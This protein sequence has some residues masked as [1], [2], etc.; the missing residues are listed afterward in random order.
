MKEYLELVEGSFTAEHEQRAQE[1]PYVAYS[2]QDDKVMYSSLTGLYQMVDLGAAGIWADRNIGA[3]SPEDAGLYFQWGDSHGYTADQVG[4][5]KVFNFDN[6]FDTTDGGSTYN[7]YNNNGGLTVLE[8]EDD[9][10]T[11]HMGSEWR[12]PTADEFSTLI[13]NTTQV[14]IDVDGNE[15]SQQE[16]Q[17]TVIASGKLKGVKFIAT[18][19]NSIFIPASGIGYSSS[20][21]GI[22]THSRLWSSDLDVSSDGAK[23][24]E[25][26]NTGGVSVIRYGRGYGHT[27]RAIKA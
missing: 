5:D 10:A 2:V 22:N 12:M 7:K 1:W 6:Y 4:V 23:D 26:N 24:L 15:F 25:I 18:N 8:S 14:F 11:V 27:I 17:G 13:N 21:T 9:A 19:G 16:A 20:I 3:S